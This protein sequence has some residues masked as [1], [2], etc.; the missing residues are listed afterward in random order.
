[1]NCG[2]W[3]P[4]TDCR[5]GREGKWEEWEWEGSKGEEGKEKENMIS[6]YYRELYT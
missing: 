6:D 1:M 4:I 2:A 5:R 3:R